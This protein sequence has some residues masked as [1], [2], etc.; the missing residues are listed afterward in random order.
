M[1]KGAYAATDADSVIIPA[2]TH[3][4]STELQRYSGSDGFIAFGIPATVDEGIRI[5]A[6]APYYHLA[7]GDPRLLMDIHMI[8]DTGL[9]QAGGYEIS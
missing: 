9:T 6:S 2:Q 1:A 5:G 4:H 3:A 8:C 7:A